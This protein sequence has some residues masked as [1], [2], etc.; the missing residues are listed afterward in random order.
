MK[1]KEVWGG[2]KYKRD[3]GRDYKRGRYIK[4]GER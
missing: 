2:R 3:L 1:I 4:L